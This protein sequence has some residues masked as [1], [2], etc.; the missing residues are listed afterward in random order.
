MRI[1]QT[2]DVWYPAEPINHINEYAFAR[3]VHRVFQDGDPGFAFASGRVGDG[4]IVRIFVLDGAEIADGLAPALSHQQER[5]KRD[6]SIPPVSNP[7]WQSVVLS[8]ILRGA[9]AAMK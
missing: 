5:N 3:K 6:P 1:K 7:R 8:I 4:G 2:P 9:A